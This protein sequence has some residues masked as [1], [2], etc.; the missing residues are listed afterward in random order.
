MVPAIH[1][2]IAPC[3][4]PS[5]PL[6]AASGGGLRPVLTAAPLDAFKTQAGTKKRALSRRTK[7]QPTALRQSFRLQI[8]VRLKNEG[9]P[10]KSTL[11]LRR[12]PNKGRIVSTMRLTAPPLMKRTS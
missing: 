8:L 11:R 1:P 12:G 2:S 6:R 10:E 4:R 9:R 7:K 5:R 3:S